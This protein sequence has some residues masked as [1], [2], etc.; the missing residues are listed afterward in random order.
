MSNNIYLVPTEN[1]EVHGEVAAI[2]KRSGSAY[3]WTGTFCDGTQIAGFTN[4]GCGGECHSITGPG[5]IRY[6]SS[7]N[8]Y[9]KGPSIPSLGVFKHYI[10]IPLARV[11]LSVIRSNSFLL[12]YSTYISIQWTG[13]PTTTMNVYS[14]NNCQDYI[15]ELQISID[16]CGPSAEPFQSFYIYYNC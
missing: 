1:S 5:S 9:G 13:I 2:E 11:P 10:P 3:I 6:A 12:V 16:N 7:A 4:V 14:D 8:L 15:Q